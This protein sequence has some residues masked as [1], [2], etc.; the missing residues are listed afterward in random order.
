MK[1][2]FVWIVVI[3]V[4][5]TGASWVAYA[6]WIDMEERFMALEP[7]APSPTQVHWAEVEQQELHDWIHGQGVA[8]AVRRR[9]LTFEVPGRVVELDETVREGARVSGPVDGGKGQLI[10]RLDDADHIEAVRIADTGLTQAERNVD[11]AK[12]QLRQSQSTEKLWRTRLDRAQALLDKKVISQQKFDEATAELEVAIANVAASEAQVVAREAGVLAA[13]NEVSRATRN[14]ERAKIYAPWDGVIARLNIREG[15]YV[16]PE[17]MSSRSEAD[18]TATFPVTLLDTS[19][20]K[21]E[22]EVP[23]HRRDELQEGSPAQILRDGD[24]EPLMAH[25]HA[26]APILSPNSRTVRVTLH[27]DDSDP[28][29]IDGELVRVKILRVAQEVPAIPVEALL[30]QDNQAKV[31]VV[32]PETWVVDERLLTT[33]IREDTVIEVSEGLLPGELVVTEGRHRLLAGDQ[34]E[35]LNFEAT[36]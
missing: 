16:L 7:P 8:R 17:E 26:V 3:C 33:G 30:Y 29:L 22:V 31:L 11:M 34:V 5:L 35:L 36:Q 10:A 28:S 14:L 1:K 4:G 24:A 9:H 19:A 21:I 27:T 25:I 13:R 6:S 23:M 15:K 18:M 20:F 12:A 32:D 2:L